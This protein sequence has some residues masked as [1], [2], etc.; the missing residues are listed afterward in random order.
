M[1][2]SYVNSGPFEPSVYIHSVIVANA[3]GKGL[4]KEP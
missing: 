4:G 3:A 1:S 2:P